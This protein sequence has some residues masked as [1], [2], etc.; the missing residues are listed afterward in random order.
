MAQSSIKRILE[1]VPTS[2]WGGGEQYVHDIAQ[3]L[4]LDG[5]D[6]SIFCKEG[7]DGEDYTYRR[8]STLS[9]QKARPDQ[10]IHVEKVSFPH[11]FSLSAYRKIAQTVRERNIQLI[12]THIFTDAFIALA[13]REL[14]HLDTRIIMTRH[15]ARIAKKDPLHRF[16]FSHLDRLFFVSRYVAEKFFSKGYSREA[17]KWQI[18]PNT[19]SKA[20]IESGRNNDGLLRSHYCIPSDHLLGAYTGRLVSEKA[21]DLIVEAAIALKDEKISFILFG[22]DDDTPYIQQLKSRLKETATDNVY[23]A[24][25]TEKV[26]SCIGQ[27]DFGILPTR[28]EE[29]LPLSALEF[30]SL[31]KP[32]IVTDRGGHSDLVREGIT[33][34]HIPIDDVSAL[35]AAIQKFIDQPEKMKEMGFAA[36]KEMQTM[37]MEHHVQNLLNL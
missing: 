23:F 35:K 33:G 12:H 31:G 5:N 3:E 20:K 14:Y 28:V 22:K 27:C 32:M 30:L 29:A 37:D 13:A 9:T 19:L 4:I 17:L 34:Y 26:M 8:M 1:I 36:E 18:N 24:G 7:K 16:I 21:V 2:I 6:V 25:F 10:E 15:L 11:K